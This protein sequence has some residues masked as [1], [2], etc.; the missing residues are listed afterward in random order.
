MST[1][2]AVISLCGTT[3][4]TAYVH[5]L[6]MQVTCGLPVPEMDAGM[7]TSSGNRR[8]PAPSVGVIYN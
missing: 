5:M 8:G 4:Y 7:S 3:A 6:C 2:M 1:C